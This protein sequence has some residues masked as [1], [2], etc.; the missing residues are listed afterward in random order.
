MPRYAKTGFSALAGFSALGALFKRI[1]GTVAGR[2][3]GGG[4]LEHLA[5]LPLGAEP[6]LVLVRLG[7]QTLLVGATA[8]RINLLA[9][10]HSDA[11]ALAGIADDRSA[12]EEAARQ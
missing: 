1:I 4:A 7:Q 6:S 9:K 11:P 10:I 2:R 5:T 8:Q 3:V 12:D